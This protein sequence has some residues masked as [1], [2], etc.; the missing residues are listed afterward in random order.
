MN[1]EENQ[2]IIKAINMFG[3]VPEM[4]EL[5][6]EIEKLNNIIE[7]LEVDLRNMYL[8]FREFSEEYTENCIKELKEELKY[9]IPIVEHNK[10]ITKHLKEIERLNN[11]INE[12][13]KEISKHIALYTDITLNDVLDILKELKGSDKK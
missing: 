10:T 3:R 13:E 5:L 2:T 1:K 12:L 8:T 4:W 11:I 7:K 6:N 9:T